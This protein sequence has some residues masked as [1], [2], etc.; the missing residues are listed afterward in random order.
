MLAIASFIIRYRGK[1]A[2]ANVANCGY[3][4]FVLRQT[5]N[6][7]LEVLLMKEYAF[8]SQGE[9]SG[10]QRNKEPRYCREM[11]ARL[12]HLNCSSI[13]PIVGGACLLA[14]TLTPSLTSRPTRSR[15]LAALHQSRSG[16][17]FI[18]HASCLIWR[19][20]AM[21]VFTKSIL[22]LI[23]CVSSLFA[24]TETQ[25]PHIMGVAHVGIYANDLDRTRVLY[26]DLLGFEEP[27]S[28]TTHTCKNRAQ[29]GAILAVPA[30]TAERREC[31]IKSISRCRDQA[32]WV[33]D[34]VPFRG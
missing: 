20:A 21:T 16:R 7:L 3:G 33:Y 22:L 23:V 1:P 13:T 19:V 26:K 29:A 4:L 11:W 18:C 17:T 34:G 2:S 32:R 14:V 15:F 27:F 5:A 25:R 24:Q 9:D 30:R 8:R 10:G 31:P 6:L 12:P 28:L